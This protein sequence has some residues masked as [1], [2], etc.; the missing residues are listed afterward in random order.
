MGERNSIKVKED[1]SI[2]KILMIQDNRDETHR[3]R[4]LLD[5]T[6]QKRFDL[7]C[8]NRL[9]SGMKRLSKGG[10]SLVLLDLSLPDSQG[11]DTFTRVHKQSPDTPVIIQGHMDD[12]SLA[13]LAV[14]EGAQDY[15]VTHNMDSTL[16]IRSI[17]YAIE[18]QR[19]VTEIRSLSLID[20]LTGLY[21][22]R[23]FITL[24]REQ[25]KIS[26]RSKEGMHFLY[27]DLDSL[28][29]INDRWGHHQG[30]N[31]LKDL[32]SILKRTFRESDILARIGGDEFCVL[33]RETRRQSEQVLSARLLDTIAQHNREAT[34]PYKISISLGVTQNSPDKPCSPEE[35]IIRADR[36]MYRD[37]RRKNDRY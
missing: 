9:S 31:A 15:L 1:P 28:K 14:Q 29:S 19:L 7:E 30:D 17:R 4:K 27:I 18:R 12:E 11:M 32:A 34:R 13:I 22:R 23:G 5:E 10:Y 35:I 36:M 26:K 6:G 25:L 2:T 20:D 24:A 8:S 37:K 3:I 16:L 33:A 21:N